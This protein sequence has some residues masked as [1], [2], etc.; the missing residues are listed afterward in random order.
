VKL[1]FGLPVSGSWATPANIRRVAQDAEANGFASLWSFQRWLA[2]ESLPPV[3][4]SVLDPMVA[5]GFA[6]A[7]TERVRLGTAIVNAPFY[8]PVALAKQF[9]SLDVLSSGR[10]DIGLGLG[11]APYEYSAA[12]VPTDGRG[13]RFAEW[14][15]CFDVLM[16]S[17]GPVEFAGEYYTVEPTRIAPAPVQ[18]PRP[19][20][21]L[22]GTAPAA[23]RR[24]GAQAD[25]WISSS[26]LS[27][28]DVRASVVAVRDAAEQVGKARDEVRCI[29]RGVTQLRDSDD[30][31]GALSGTL[32]KIRDGLATYAAAGVDEVFLDLNFDNQLVGNPAADPQQALDIAATLMPLGSETF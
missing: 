12:G 29:V 7:V 20:V 31:K 26:R 6:A 22:G 10:V 9:A 25:G 24:A 15:R 8:A 23:L 16:T 17:D 32:D 3:Y 5:L 14:L 18:R 1:G 27:L 21:L 19:P 4:Q 2:D 28:A 13:K 11:W 30:A